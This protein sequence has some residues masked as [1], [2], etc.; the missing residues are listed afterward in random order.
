MVSQMSPQFMINL[1]H[2]RKHTDF[3]TPQQGLRKLCALYPVE[4]V[5]IT[6]SPRMYIHFKFAINGNGIV[7]G[8]DPLIIR[9]LTD[10]F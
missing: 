6:D 3:C 9:T 8:I 7:N 4:D 5:N 10:S 1:P 2:L